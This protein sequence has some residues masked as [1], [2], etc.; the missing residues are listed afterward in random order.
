[1]DV[2]K[3]IPG[4]IAK[5]SYF[6]AAGKARGLAFTPV[7]LYDTY[8]ALEQGKPVLEALEQ[9][10]IGTDAIGGTKRILALTP[11]ERTARSVV[12]QDAIQDL[13]LDM[14]MGFGFIEGPTPKT[15]MTLEEAQA[16]AK[17]GDERVRA[18]EAHKNLETKTNRANFFGN[19]RDRIF[20]APQSLSFAGGGIAKQAG[21]PSGPP[22][23]SGPNSQGLS[24]LLKRGNKI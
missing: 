3:S 8:K 11:V 14:P 19:L 22:P 9:G 2:A 15:N 7:M 10:L 12:K 16:K 13:N 1:M 23:E 4:D 17:A 24:G 18:L 20:G 5:K 21:D 6:K